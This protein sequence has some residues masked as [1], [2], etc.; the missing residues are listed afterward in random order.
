MTRI[1]Q[2]QPAGNGASGNG[3]LEFE[4]PLASIERQIRELE[5]SQAQT[6]RDYSDTI[7][8]MRAE[9]TNALKKT[10]SRLS[11]WE[12]V[13]VARH[14]Q[15]PLVND[16]LA[17]LGKDFCELH[18]DR[19]FRDDKAIIAGMVRMAGRKVMLV[20][21]RKGRDTKEKVDCCFGCAHPEGYRKA[22]RAMKLAEK[23]RLPVVSL[24][25]TSGAYPG[26]GA[27]E[28]G[29]AQAI[30]QCMF[31]MSRLKVP[32]VCVVIGEGGSGGALAIGVGDRVAM[33]EYSYYSVIPP[34]GCAAILW[35]SGEYASD[36]ATALKPTARELKKL[37]IVDQII[38][39]PLG[40][41]HR[42]PQL[43]A[44]EL[45]K[46]LSSALNTLIK[47][48]TDRL[49]KQRRQRLRDV[50][51]FFEHAG[52]GKRAKKSPR[53]SGN[54]KARQGNGK[55]RNPTEGVAAT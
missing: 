11:P 55:T 47:L 35:R 32:I 26:I 30:A 54:G 12:I 43:A 25:D 27:E 53:R 51:S 16:Y 22:L 4:R 34:E 49:L 40:A 10:Y 31:E 18:G 39:E 48:P 38:R 50:G 2:P 19:A 23:F 36:A 1:T 14:P 9:L 29:Q 28:R 7:T 46:F 41:A 24:I 6:G 37:G 20:G 52:N 17:M 42:D 15:R 3:I 13:L 33:M 21:N 45:D 8:A 5:A 44:A